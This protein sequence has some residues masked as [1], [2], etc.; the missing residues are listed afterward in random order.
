MGPG[1][2]A[3]I[4]NLTPAGLASSPLPPTMVVDHIGSLLALTARELGGDV[5]AKPKQQSEL[6]CR[7]QRKL[8]SILWQSGPTIARA[9]WRRTSSP[10][11]P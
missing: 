11:S 9:S 1:S 4:G 3:F 6:A 5:A 10:T 7:I 2:A 8:T